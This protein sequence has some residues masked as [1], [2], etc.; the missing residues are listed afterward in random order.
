[1]HNSWCLID[2]AMI[3]SLFILGCTDNAARSVVPLDALSFL[4]YHLAEVKSQC[5]ASGHHK[6]Y[7]SRATLARYGKLP[8]PEPVR[9]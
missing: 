2:A 5:T 3:C 6:A 1:M 7:L 9:M 8:T 4:A